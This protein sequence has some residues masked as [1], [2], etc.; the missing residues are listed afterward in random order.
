MSPQIQT[1]GNLC[2]AAAALVTLLPLSRLLSSYANQY[3]NDDRWTTSALRVLVPLW[4]FLMGGLLCAT[5]SGAFDWLP[6]GRGALSAFMVA[7]SVALGAVT[8][9]AHGSY[10]RPGFTPRRIYPPVIYLVS[11]TTGLVALLGL[12]P[13]L[14]AAIPLQW[15][16]VPW[17]LF[18]VLSL[19]LCLGFAGHRFVK[20]GF[21]V[22]S[23]V[24]RLLSTRIAAS[25]QL[26]RIPTVDVQT[27]DGFAALLDLADGDHPRRV[28][29]AATARLR[30]RADFADRLAATL[31]N[32]RRASVALEFIHAATLT[33]EEQQR[34]GGPVRTALETFIKDVPAP[35]YMTRS[36]QRALLRFGRRSFPRIIGKFAGTG[37]DYSGIMPAL[38]RA[39]RP[40]DSRR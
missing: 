38:E 28:R 25:D 2:V 26:A 4:L 27:E 34:L 20:T 31:A 17:A 21:G 23:I 11:L 12:N 36:R 33:A 22:R 40:D 8:F 14:A 35:N 29:E 16:R 24:R 19:V 13:G 37:V 15:L 7:A 39:L 5:A 3:P 1:I 30:E 10:I 9:A 18:A 32:S 6:L